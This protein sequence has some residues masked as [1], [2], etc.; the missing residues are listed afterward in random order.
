[1]SDIVT[2]KIEAEEKGV[3]NPPK[4]SGQ[5]APAGKQATVKN[6]A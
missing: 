6:M 3:K 2:D 4:V 5:V 1:V